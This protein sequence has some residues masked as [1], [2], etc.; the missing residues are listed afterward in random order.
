MLFC[1]IGH[2]KRYNG[3]MTEL[4][5]LAEQLN[6]SERTLRRAVGQGAL[7]AR[8]PSPRRLEISVGEKRYA[9]RAWP[10]LASLREA[11]RTEANV[12]FALL[13]GSAA[14]GDDSAGSDID[15]LVEMRDN[16]MERVADLSAKLEGLADR[17]VDVILLQS[18][19]ALPG[20]LANAIAEGRVLLD[21]DS[22]WTELQEREGALR[23][24]ALRRDKRRRRA[25]LK[26]IDRMRAA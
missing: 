10:M 15:L 2:M 11:L 24:E 1:L 19:E 25:A 4:G 13:F 12:R 8:R 18:A 6:V 22:R 17:R 23:R 26:G 21:R 16:S 20:L 14:R 5:L 3:H 9:R 7:R